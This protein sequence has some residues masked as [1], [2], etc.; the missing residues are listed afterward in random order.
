VG[1]SAA[2]GVRLQLMASTMDNRGHTCPRGDSCAESRSRDD[3]A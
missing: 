3:G 2:G 1:P